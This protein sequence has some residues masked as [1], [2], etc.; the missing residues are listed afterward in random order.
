MGYKE[1]CDFSPFSPLFDMTPMSPPHLQQQSPLTFPEHQEP[2]EAAE[3][4]PFFHQNTQPEAKE[5]KVGDRW[6]SLSTGT[7]SRLHHI[8]G[9]LL[10]HLPAGSI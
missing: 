6:V 4:G 3:L 5:P 1:H 7:F 10:A 9:N 8:L 2:S